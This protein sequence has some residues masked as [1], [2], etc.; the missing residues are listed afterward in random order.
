M[1]RLKSFV[2]MALTLSAIA[3][4]ATVFE[5]VDPFTGNITY[6]NAPPRTQE[7]GKEAPALTA[8][9]EPSAVSQT[10]KAHPAARTSTP[11]SFPRIAAATQRER[12][13]DRLQ[14]LDEELKSEQE[15]L[16]GAIT[17]TSAEHVIRRHKANIEALQR[18]IQKVK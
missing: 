14:I 8:K 18:E 10:I 16:N 9:P 6:S 11:A 7:R 4:E 12:D 17:K 1:K 5:H 15:A 3:A 2:C 13:N